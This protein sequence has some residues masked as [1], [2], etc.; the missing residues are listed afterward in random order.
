MDYCCLGFAGH[1]EVAGRR[2]MSIIADASDELG[3]VFVV[4]HRAVDFGCQLQIESPVPVSLVTESR[5]QYCPWC[6][7]SLAAFYGDTVKEVSRSKFQSADLIWTLWAS[8][9][10]AT[11]DGHRDPDRQPPRLQ[12]RL[13]ARR[14]AKESG[15]NGPYR[16]SII[17]SRHKRGSSK[18]VVHAGAATQ[19]GAG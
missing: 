18:A 4:Q 15:P 8:T 2:G 9:P 6:G 10:V 16:R 14:R 12:P 3:P 5:I 17:L 19:E 7:T 11:I 13:P 1:M